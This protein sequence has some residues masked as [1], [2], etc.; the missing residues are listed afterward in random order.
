LPGGLTV[1]KRIRLDRTSA[2]SSCNSSASPI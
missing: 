1:L 2:V